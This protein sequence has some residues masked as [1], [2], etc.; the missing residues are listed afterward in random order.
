MR[1]CLV[2]TYADEYVAIA[3]NMRLTTTSDA[4]SVVLMKRQSRFPLQSF[5]FVLL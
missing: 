2:V 3:G 5:C 1:E 4:A